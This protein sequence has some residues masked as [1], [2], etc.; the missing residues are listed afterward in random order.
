MH[1]TQ[2]PDGWRAHHNGDFAGEV[3]LTHQTP[4]GVMEIEVPFEVLLNLVMNYLQSRM[5]ARIEYMTHRELA[6]E[7]V[8]RS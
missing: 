8:R 6:D 7:I 2:L 5:V 4:A 1:T 3:R